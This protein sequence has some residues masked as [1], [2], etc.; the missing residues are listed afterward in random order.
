VAVGTLAHAVFWLGTTA[1]GLV[2][3]RLGGRRLSEAL[4]SAEQG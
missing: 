2:A 4:A 1:F 3:L